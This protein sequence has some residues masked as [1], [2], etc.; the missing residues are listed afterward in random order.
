MPGKD[1]N[2]VDGKK[3]SD[4]VHVI[5]SLILSFKLTDSQYKKFKKRLNQN[6]LYA[7]IQKVK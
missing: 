2:E 6:D 3:S 1:D 5:F 7:I 4:Y